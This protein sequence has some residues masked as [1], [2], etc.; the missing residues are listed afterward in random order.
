MVHVF[1]CNHRLNHRGRNY[2][3][4]KNVIQI[5]LFG[6]KHRVMAKTLQHFQMIERYFQIAIKLRIPVAT[7]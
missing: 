7:F 3:Y 5:E 6:S 4:T 1:G 2:Y